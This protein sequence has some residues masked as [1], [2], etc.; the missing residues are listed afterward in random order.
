MWTILIVHLIFLFGNVL[1]V[2]GPPVTVGLFF[3]GN[4]VAH[5]EMADHR[6]FFQAIRSYWKPAWRWGF[7]NFFIFGMLLGDYYL[8]G[9]LTSSLSTAHFLQGFYVTLILFWLL[10]QLFALPFLFEQEQP[11]VLQALRNSIVF[12]RKNL[13][14][15]VALGILLLLSLTLGTLA[16]MLTFAFGGALI[17]FAGNHAVLDHLAN[18]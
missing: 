17:A 9:K 13:I 5:G 8:T 14:F 1:I 7:L 15:A 3:Y 2:L 11:R 12:I 4:R 6:D 10:I 16:F 18:P